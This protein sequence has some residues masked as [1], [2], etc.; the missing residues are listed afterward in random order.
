MVLLKWTNAN[1]LEAPTKSTFQI[2]SALDVRRSQGGVSGTSFP[3]SYQRDLLNS[4]QAKSLNK[5]S[6]DLYTLQATQPRRTSRRRSSQTPFSI[7]IPAN[8]HGWRKVTETQGEPHGYHSA[9]SNGVCRWVR[10]GN[11]VIILQLSSKSFD[12]H[13]SRY[14]SLG[15]RPAATSVRRCIPVVV[16]PASTSTGIRTVSFWTSW[17]ASRGAW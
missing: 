4:S 16:A 14:K 6:H 7:T 10:R 9:L 13:I 3:I 12:D 1:P 15:R 2:R 8:K 5:F 11:N 17:R